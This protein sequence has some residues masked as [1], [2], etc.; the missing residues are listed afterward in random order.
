MFE[1]IY[2]KHRDCTGYDEC[3]VKVYSVRDN[4]G[5]NGDKCP[6]FLIFIDGCWMWVYSFYCVPVE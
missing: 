6:E 1:V 5:Y 3:K 2:Q 4:N